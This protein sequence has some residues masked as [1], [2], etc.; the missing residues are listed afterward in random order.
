M[1]ELEELSC[2]NLANLLFTNNIDLSK[3]EAIKNLL[4][5]EGVSTS[6]IDKKINDIKLKI[7]DIEMIAIKKSCDIKKLVSEV[8]ILGKIP[9]HFDIVKVILINYLRENKKIRTKEIYNLIEEKTG[10]K[11]HWREV[12]DILKR[13]VNR[14][15]LYRKAGGKRIFF[16]GKT[17][18][19]YHE[20][21]MVIPIEEIKEEIKEM[22]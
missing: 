7:S 5:S 2:N 10:K 13:L 22:I 20:F 3:V 18:P 11:I 17:M 16:R 19:E 15:V 4:I 21:Y 9:D 8:E 1:V 14:G 12:G 6:D